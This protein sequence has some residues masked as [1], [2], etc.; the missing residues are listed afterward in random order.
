M[1][2]MENLLSLMLIHK[3][4][5]ESFVLISFTFL[6]FSSGELRSDMCSKTNVVIISH[7][8]LSSFAETIL[9]FAKTI[10]LIVNLFIIIQIIS[11]IVFQ[12]D[13]LSFI[14][15]LRLFIVF[16]EIIFC[17]S[18]ILLPFSSLLLSFTAP[19][20]IAKRPE[21]AISFFIFEN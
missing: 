6:S 21:N 9:Q 15:I 8:S 20:T 3:S 2:V 10:I 4:K 5:K 16:K 18:R 12:F 1:R 11:I 13:Y 19:K 14:V 17:F 7:E